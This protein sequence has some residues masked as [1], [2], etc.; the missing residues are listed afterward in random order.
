MILARKDAVQVLPDGC[1][2]SCRYAFLSST[3][4]GPAAQLNL[5]LRR[6]PKVA[7]N[8]FSPL[9]ISC[10]AMASSLP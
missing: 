8:A 6:D 4:E 9:F 1:E 3:T 7:T 2:D 5:S 10:T